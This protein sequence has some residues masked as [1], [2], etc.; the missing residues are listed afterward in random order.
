MNRKQKGKIL[1]DLL[2]HYYPNPEVP[3]NFFSP[4]SL[5]VAVLL[6]QQCTDKKVNEI[7]PELFAHAK[8]PHE[9]CD[10]GVS[11]IQTIIR[12]IGL[13]ATKAKNIFALSQILVEKYNSVVPDDLDKL[14]ALPGVGRKTALCVLAQAFHQDAFPVDTHILRLA[15]RWGLSTSDNPNKVED[16]LKKVFPKKTWSKVHLQIIFAGR[17]HCKAMRH[18]PKKCPFC[19]QTSSDRLKDAIDSPM[20]T[21]TSP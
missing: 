14:M 11:K 6:S 7:T 2:D 18:D 19:S 20:R 10:L 1:L 3:L 17:E 5:L 9:M 13:S 4:F 15:K 12:P 8:T 21:R 16:D